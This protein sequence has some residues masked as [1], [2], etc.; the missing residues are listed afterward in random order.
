MRIDEALRD[1]NLL[2]AA[3][4]DA[5]TYS[6]WLAILRA[7]YGLPLSA[8]FA[9]SRDEERYAAALSGAIRGME[10]RGS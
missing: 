3:L 5:S 10:R 4:G 9:R 1:Q 8:E 7:T 6:T 2:G